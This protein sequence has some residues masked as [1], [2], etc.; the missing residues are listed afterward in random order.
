MTLVCDPLKKQVA[1]DFVTPVV[2]HS[3]FTLCLLFS[4]PCYEP[5]APLESVELCA[6]QNSGKTDSPAVCFFRK[7][8]L[9]SLFNLQPPGDVLMSPYPLLLL[10]AVIQL[11]G[12][13]YQNFESHTPE[14]LCPGFVR[15]INIS[16]H[17]LL[18]NGK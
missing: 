17:I 7:T 16:K 3:V 5:L 1:G 9:V 10:W 15:P 4:V 6:D 8:Y 11:P 12:A 18:L 13:F 2:V 14:S